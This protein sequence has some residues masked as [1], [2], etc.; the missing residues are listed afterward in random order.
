MYSGTLAKADI[1]QLNLI[2]EILGTP[3]DEFMKKIS[4]ESVSYFSFFFFI[5]DILLFKLF[6]YFIKMHIFHIIYE[7]CSPDIFFSYSLIH[8]YILKQINILNNISI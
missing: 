8:E 7:S 6:C 3:R 2:M 4:S 5:I 1:H